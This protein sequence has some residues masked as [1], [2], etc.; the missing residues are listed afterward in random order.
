MSATGQATQNPALES[1]LP[2]RWDEPTLVAR[3]NLS[4]LVFVVKGDSKWE[5]LADV[6]AAVKANPSRYRY[7]LSGTGGVGSIA[8]A[9]LINA[10][11]VNPN[12][13]GNV[14]LQGGAPLL[15]AVVNGETHFAV[16]YQAEMQDLIA[17]KKIKPLAVSTPDRTAELPDVP[18]GREAGYPAFSLI[19]WNGI[20]G[21]ANLPADVVEQW[22]VSVREMVR[23][24]TFLD[25][26]SRLGA[27]AAYLGPKEFKA[28]LHVEYETALLLAQRLRIRK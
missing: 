17:E 12:D 1:K 5:S 3:T 11:G 27:T 22:D 23:D 26:M 20:V 21:P 16:Q 4:P 24:P 15:A 19:G 18:S 14:P 28:A 6:V 2:Y 8:L 13:V 7:G 25:E 10:V 9:Q